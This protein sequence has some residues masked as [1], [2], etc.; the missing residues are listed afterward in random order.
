MPRIYG[1][2]LGFAVTGITLKRSARQPA[3]LGIWRVNPHGPVVP[4]SPLPV[5][6]CYQRNG[7]NLLASSQEAKC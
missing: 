2:A 5:P 6:L 1:F 4:P 7:S 3:T